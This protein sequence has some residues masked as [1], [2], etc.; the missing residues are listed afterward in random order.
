MI[1]LRRALRAR[2]ER[3]STVVSQRTPSVIRTKSYQPKSIQN[4]GLGVLHLGVNAHCSPASSFMYKSHCQK[5][6]LVSTYIKISIT[7]D[8]TN[9]PVQRTPQLRYRKEAQSISI[10]WEIRTISRLPAFYYM[11]ILMW[12]TL[13]TD[14]CTYAT[15]ATIKLCVVNDTIACRGCARL[16]IARSEVTGCRD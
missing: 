7:N 11:K 4:G 15:E 8:K 2:N 6:L 1:R 5:S 16:P 3:I 10:E 14:G 9:I 13:G 12:V